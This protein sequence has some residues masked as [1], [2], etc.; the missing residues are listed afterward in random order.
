VYIQSVPDNDT[1]DVYTVY[2][3]E[4]K[5]NVKRA[6]VVECSTKFP[7][8]AVIKE[9]NIIFTDCGDYLALIP[10]KEYLAR[11]DNWK[12]YSYII[13]AVQQEEV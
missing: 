6:V 5:G 13:D 8:S 10:T 3:F 2:T 12:L 7:D 1:L 4:H 11:E 9:S